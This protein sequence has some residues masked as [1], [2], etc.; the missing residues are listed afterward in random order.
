MTINRE[1]PALLPAGIHAMDVEG[2]ERRCVAGFLESNSRPHIMS[3]LKRFIQFMQGIGIKGEL[4]LDGSFV[5]EKPEPSDVDLVFVP[6]PPTLQAAWKTNAQILEA[7]FSRGEAKSLFL[8]D[9]YFCPPENAD[10]LAYWRGWFGFFRDG[11]T[12]K[13]IAKLTL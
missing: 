7:L 13:G 11:V 1:W 3:G 8:C 6:D 9:A 5:T 4:W 10:R 2:I 12:P